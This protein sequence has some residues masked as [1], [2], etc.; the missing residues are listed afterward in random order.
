[1]GG[2]VIDLNCTLSQGEF[3][4]LVGI[5]QQAVSDLQRRGV[6]RHNTVGSAWL[7]AYCEHLRE[8]A[9]GRAGLL[10]DSSAKLKDAQ[11]AEVELRLAL[12]RREV[13][14]VAVI[15]QVLAR[16]GRQA[17]A[18]LEGLVPDLR[19]RWPDVSAEQLKLVEE[20]VVRVRN[21]MSGLTL[22]DV[23]QPDGDSEA[24]D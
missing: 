12:K 17:A 6:L 4:A 9:A 8:E 1:M 11:R 2:C 24:E 19:R 5:T 23:H 20:A 15:S 3:A 7:L 22:V 21:L 18:V 14:P 16:V 13:A 10:A